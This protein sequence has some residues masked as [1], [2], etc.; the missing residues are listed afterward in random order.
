MAGFSYRA[1][2]NKESQT[3]IL[4]RQSENVSLKET[5]VTFNL[6]FQQKFVSDDQTVNVC[7]LLMIHFSH[8]ALLFL[9]ET[10][11]LKMIM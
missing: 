3:E 1:T 2:G 9:S 4:I 10:E 6:H 7:F 5:E 11:N 8:D